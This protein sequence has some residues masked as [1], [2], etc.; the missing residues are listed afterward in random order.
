M[1]REVK[2][3]KEWLMGIY[4]AMQELI[5]GIEKNRPENIQIQQKFTSAGQKLV[6]INKAIGWEANK[7]INSAL[8]NLDARMNGGGG[9]RSWNTL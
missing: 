4:T 3:K 7:G 2:R 8:R 9:L 6:G 1:I 5:G